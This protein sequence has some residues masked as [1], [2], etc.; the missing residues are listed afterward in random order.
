[1]RN[2]DPAEPRR[3][4]RRHR[5]LPALPPAQPPAQPPRLRRPRV[6]C[7]CPRPPLGNL[8]TGIHTL[9][10]DDSAPRVLR[11]SLV[12]NLAMRHR[13]Q[14]YISRRTLSSVLLALLA[15]DAGGTPLPASGRCSSLQFF[16]DLVHV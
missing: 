2:A 13:L 3:D 16:P 6:A 15:N 10:S 11:Q 4:R 1:M 5:P 9:L 14:S 12:R 7:R 8:H